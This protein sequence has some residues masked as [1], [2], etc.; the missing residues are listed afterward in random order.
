MHRT[1]HKPVTFT[2]AETTGLHAVGTKIIVAAVTNTAVEVFVEHDFIALIAV[3]RPCWNRLDGFLDRHDTQSEV[4]RGLWEWKR[5]GSLLARNLTL[6]RGSSMFELEDART[7]VTIKSGRHPAA[8]HG[9][10]RDDRPLWNFRQLSCECVGLVQRLFQVVVVRCDSGLEPQL[11]FG[12][13][14]ADECLEDSRVALVE[15]DVATSRIR[16]ALKDDLLV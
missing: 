14:G 4:L 8:R 15:S 6:L 10:S 7:R 5:D 13:G 12:L 3:Y 2:W 11:Q 16:E 9:T 1:L